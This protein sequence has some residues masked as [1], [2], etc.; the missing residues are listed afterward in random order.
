MKEWEW[1]EIIIK[2]NPEGKK[3]CSTFTQYNISAQAGTGQYFSIPFP[4]EQK[5]NWYE[6]CDSEWS[7]VLSLTGSAC[8]CQWDIYSDKGQMCGQQNEEDLLVNCS[9]KAE[10]GTVLPKT[11]HHQCW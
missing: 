2:I 1:I 5:H 8:V 9:T 3:G 10:C 7:V 6:W 11:D 4:A